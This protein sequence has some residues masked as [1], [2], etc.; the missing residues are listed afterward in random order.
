MSFESE[1][2][3]LIIKQYWDKPKAR[4]EIELQ[5]ATW[6]ITFQWLQSFETEFDIDLAT[7]ERLDI[8][9]RIVGINRIVPFVLDKIAF[10]FDENPNAR[11]FD[12]KFTGPLVGAAPFLDKFEQP[13]TTLQLNDNDYRFF[14][15]AKIAKNAGSA[16]MVG[17]GEVSIQDVINTTFDGR[18]YV[19]DRQDMSLALY[20]SPVFDLERLRAIQRLDLLPKPQ[21]VRY[22]IIVQAA[23]GETF[24]F[25]DNPNALGFANKFDLANEPGGRFAIKVIM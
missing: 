9:G 14:M 2:R 18:A 13:Y 19:V 3:D 23:P 4:A 25:S 8:L 11:G 10:G 7:G 6:S 15:K 17:D 22:D 5:A 12:D 1:Y 20:V 21:G 16:Y 24:G